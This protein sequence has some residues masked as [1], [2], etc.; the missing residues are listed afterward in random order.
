MIHQGLPF[1]LMLFGIQYIWL[2]HELKQTS[3]FEFSNVAEPE[4]HHNVLYWYL[5]F[6]LYSNVYAIGKWLKSEP[7]PYSLHFPVPEPEQHDATPA[8]LYFLYD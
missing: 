1:G 4:P 3:I 8:S 2:K 6:V 5:N 7:G